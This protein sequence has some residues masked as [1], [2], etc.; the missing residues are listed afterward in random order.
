VIRRKLRAEW[1]RT[2]GTAV[3]LQE[4]AVLASSETKQPVSIRSDAAVS[5]GGR[6]A[7]LHESPLTLSACRPCDR[8]KDFI[9]PKRVGE[10]GEQRP[11]RPD[12]CL[13]AATGEAVVPHRCRKRQAHVSSQRAHAFDGHLDELAPTLWRAPQFIRANHPRQSTPDKFHAPRPGP[14]DR[15]PKDVGQRRIG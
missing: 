3:E 9:G 5:A 1:R 4:E 8:G 11:A 15:P 14:P 2:H 13:W 7:P 12:R 10:V 6:V